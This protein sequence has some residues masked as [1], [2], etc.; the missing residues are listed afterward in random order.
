MGTALLLAG[1]G[2]GGEEPAATASGAGPVTV[3][4]AYILPNGPVAGMFGEV[5]N[6]GP[7]PV[8]LVGGSAPEVGMVQIHEYVKEGTK[9][10][11]REIPG[12]LEVPAGGSVRLQPGGYHVMLMQV[13]AD[14]NVGDTVPVTLQLAGGQTV[15]VEAEVR[16]R[17]GM[18]GAMEMP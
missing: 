9:E 8:T 17:E 5:V 4:E 16:Q 12:G 15:A 2:G 7:A 14:W 3:E 6:P 11:M 1:C 13:S 18:D 10:T